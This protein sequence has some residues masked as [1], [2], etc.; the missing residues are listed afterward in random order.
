MYRG[1]PWWGEESGFYTKILQLAAKPTAA[2]S[3]GPSATPLVGEA[4]DWDTGSSSTSTSTFLLDVLQ[5]NYKHMNTYV[6]I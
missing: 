1:L 2:H 5:V 4:S 6:M 3:V